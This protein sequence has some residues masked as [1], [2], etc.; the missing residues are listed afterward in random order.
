MAQQT[1][2]LDDLMDLL[3]RRVGL[4]ERHRTQRAD[5]RFTD[6]DLDSLAFL[7]LQIQLRETYGVELPDD[8]A[9]ARTLGEIVETVRRGA[10]SEAAA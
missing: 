4:E 9:H 10:V 1:F 6:L 3:V 7:E 2:S 5:L 8:R